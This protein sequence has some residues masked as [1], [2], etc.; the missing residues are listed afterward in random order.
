MGFRA[1]LSG[2]AVV[3]ALSLTAATAQAASYPTPHEAD[4]IA[5]SFIFHTGEVL[6]NLRVH[7]TTVGDPKGEPVL[8][9]HGTNGSA[10]SMMGPGYAGTLFGPGQPLDASKYF[11]VLPDAVG[12]GQS[13]KPSDGLRAKFPVYNY[14]D[15]VLAQYRLVTEGLKLKH[16][17]LVTGNSMG[18]MQTW[19]WGEAHPDFMDALVPMAS[20]PTAMAS[21]NWMMRRMIVDAVRNDPAWQNGNYTTQPPMLRV[22][23]AFFGIATSGGSLAYQHLAPTREAADKL[24]NERLAAPFTVD[25]ND[26]LYQWDSSRDYDPAPRLD[27]I[28]APLLAINSA[29]DERNPPE[30]GLLAAAVKLLPA[31]QIYLIPASTET[32]GHGTTGMAKFYATQLAAFLATAPRRGE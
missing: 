18:G 5:P 15:M 23:N 2:L 11:I 30:T 22:A 28:R 25:A 8:V 13:T 21:R 29:D 1:M 32:R 31:G 4:W 27:R 3:A 14:D 20:L 12:A 19:M 26:T 7:Y 9:L 16:L 6:H 24:L 10:K 17:R